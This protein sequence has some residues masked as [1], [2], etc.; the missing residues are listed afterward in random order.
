MAKIISYATSASRII[1]LLKMPTKYQEFFLPLFV[2]PTDFWLVFNFEQTHTVTTFGE[3]SI[4]A[5]ITMIA[6]PIRALELHYLT[7]QFFIISLIL[8][9][10]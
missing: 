7:I 2:K 5:H 8:S 4:M 10:L 9:R 6:K 1:V 3:Q